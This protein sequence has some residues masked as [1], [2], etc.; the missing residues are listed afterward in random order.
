MKNCYFS[1]IGKGKYLVLLLFSL[2]AFG[3]TP[4]QK[5][6]LLEQYDLTKI[7]QLQIELSEK[8]KADKEKAYF[9]AKINQ[10]DVFKINSD[11]SVDELMGLLSD[12]SP[13]YYSINNVDAAVSTRANHLH[14]G[15]SLGLNLNGQG[16]VGGVWDGGPVRTSHQEFGGRIS[17]G[18]NTFDLNGN[19]FHATHVTGTV[20]A[21]GIDFNAKGMAF[22]ATVKTFDWTEDESEVLGEIQEGLL[23]SN[24]SYGMRLFN[25][26][27][28][29]AG[30]YSQDAVQW[31]LI[32]YVSPYYLMVAAA[33]NDG[34]VNNDDPTTDGFDKL[35][36][37]KNGKNNLIVG[38]AQD[39]EIDSNGN[40]ISVNINSASSEGPTDDLRIKPDITGNGTGVYST[41]SGSDDDYTSLSGTSMASPNVMGTLLLLQ[42]HH[43]NLY[44][45]FMKSATLKGL[46]CQTADDAGNPGPDAVFGWGLL[47]AKNAANS[48]SNNGLSTWISEERL[49]Q[50]QVYTKTLKSKAGQ[51]LIA[52]ICWTDIPGIANT[53]NL[54][55]PTPAIVHDLDIRITQGNAV[56]YP[57]RLQAD[58][59]QNALRNGDNFVDTV[60]TIQ[61]DNANGG[62]YLITISHKGT[63]QTN[64]Q[65]FSLII[66]GVDS[67]FGFVPL[68]YNQVV[69][70]SENAVFP[71]SFITSN[72]ENVTLST[73][74]L[75]PGA[76]ANFNQNSI[77]TNGTYELILSDL[78]GV[79]PGE[80]SI[81]IVA[82]N[83]N[84]TETRF[85]NLKVLRA[86][87]VPVTTTF[88][89]NGQTTVPSAITL[90]WEEDINAENYV[91]DVAT[92]AG[93]N[94]IVW[95]ENTVNNSINITD[96]IAQ[97]VYYW[98][99]TPSNRCG[100]ANSFTV[101]NF[102]TGIFD[103][104]IEFTATDFSDAVIE[105]TANSTAS[106]PISVSGGITIA[107]VN[108]S[109]NISHTWVQDMTIYL[110]GPEE[111]G[112][113]TITL[114]EEACGGQDDIDVTVDDSGT[115]IVC[116]S[117][118]AIS[119][120]V[121]PF[122]PLNAF[123]GVL[124][125]GE[126]TLFVIDKYNNDGGTINS[127]SL[128]FCN[129]VSIENDLNFT[130]NGII[131]EI[132]SV[133]TITLEEMNAFTTLQAASNQVYTLLELP[134]LG[135]LKKENT[136]LIIGDIFTQED[137]N[138]NKINYT[139]SLSD[140]ASDFFKVNII[141]A[142]SAWLPNVVI[143]ITIE[144][145]LSLIEN[146]TVQALIY[147]NPT[148]GKVT[149][150]WIENL[151]TNIDLFDLHGRIILSKKINASNTVVDLNH[152]SDGIYLISIQNEKVKTT[153][154]IVLK[155]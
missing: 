94:T 113:P 78:T 72:N 12:G 137:I 61:I 5:K 141:N 32:H 125:D 85:V 91:V 132:N 31:D 73:I 95:S 136:P 153:R 99:V 114:F 138:L 80:Y 105:N 22:Q 84:E 42:Q 115:S 93:F 34:N 58:A 140:A 75:P 152:F 28:W 10:W 146:E 110:I 53:G 135:V 48:I 100:E 106:I 40:L 127:V 142:S 89:L 63:L 15:G 86:E 88:P 134:S 69:C 3:Q 92:D 98:R 9:S 145:N 24:H 4:E 126:W 79:E 56:F 120:T 150:S 109:M 45:R 25:V 149:V 96:L 16:M 83:P 144:N 124:A 131:T 108:V 49:S 74:N 39:A 65:D 117:N 27:S 143:P 122:Q 76:N 21:S 87:F 111:I 62:D 129:S 30:A 148:N 29:Y 68:G 81:G 104:G 66:S 46:A 154:K 155:K 41:N 103:C 130:N 51:P 82:S 36:G 71:F 33:G 90:S 14:A 47:N 133:K 64:F 123:N 8:A 35:T 59:T 119:G 13:K 50:N 18:D 128:S 17:V 57:W 44:Q 112:S 23:L 121:L 52:T 139:N 60:E 38:N 102:Q 1:K 77:S 54:N 55:D 147:P 19:S 151:E 2:S 97:T 118:P 43:N 116:A 20:G 70:S 101:S 67:D 37:H 7:K 11:G 6:A 26:P 107:D